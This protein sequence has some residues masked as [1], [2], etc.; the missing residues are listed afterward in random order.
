[1]TTI[2]SLRKHR[3]PTPHDNLRALFSVPDDAPYQQE[4]TAVLTLEGQEE[5]YAGKLYVFAPYLCFLSLDKKSVQFTIPLSTVRRVERLNSRAGVYA[6]SLVTWHNLKIVVQLTSLRPAADAFSGHLRDSLKSQLEL[7]RMKAVK[8]FSRTLYSEAIIPIGGTA[9]TDKEREDGSVIKDPDAPEDGNAIQGEYLGGLGFT[10]KFPGDAKKLR[11]AS[12]IKLWTN[13]MRAHGRHLT[14]LRYPQA[15]RLIQVGLPNRLR[16]ELWETLSGSLYLRF[17]NP[18]LYQK[19]LDDNAGK[20][21]TSTEEIEKDLNRSLPEYAAYQTPQGIGALRRVLTAYSWKN[22]EVGYC[23]A[24]NILVAAIL[25]FMSEEQAFWLLEVLCDRLLPG[26]YVPSMYGTLLDQRVFESLVHKCL[27]IIHDR[28]HEIDVQ[29]S[30]ASLPW[31]LSL[32]IN[33]M[34]L[35]FA[36]RI[37][38]CVLAMGPKVLFQVGTLHNV[39]ILK[40]NGEKLLEISD[41]G[42]FIH[43]MRD[44][45]ASLGDSAHPNSSDPRTRAITNFQELLLVSFREFS[46]ITEE[47][48]AAERK[49]FRT[50]IVTGIESFSKRAA[51][52]NLRTFGTLTKV[53]VGLVYEVLFQSVVDCPPDDVRPHADDARDA[54]GRP[55]TRIGLKTFRVFLSQIATWARDE[56]IVSNGFI[57]RT[58]RDVP[59]HEFINRLFFFWDTNQRG[60]L[61]YQDLVLGLSGVMN[62]DLMSNIEWFFT[63]HDSDRDGYLTKDELLQLSEA[64]LFI[65]R[66]E[67]GDA[68]LGAVSRFMTN[69]FEYGDALLAPE[70]L[71]DGNAEGFSPKKPYLNLATFR[72]VVLADEILESFFDTD[73]SASFQLEPPPVPEELKPQ[74]AGFFG[75]LVSSIMN[76]NDNR[77]IFNNVADSIGRSMGKHQVTTRP[78]IGKFDKGFGLQEPKPRESLLTPTVSGRN[79]SP[80]ASSRLSEKTVDTAATSTGG[81]SQKTTLIDTT[82]IKSDSDSISLS[83]SSTHEPLTPLVQ[84]LSN[85]S[86]MERTHFTIDDAADGDDDDLDDLDAAGGGD[87]D[88]SMMDEV[89]AF[90]EAHDSGLT[91]A[92]NAAAKDLLSAPAI[93]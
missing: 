38:D 9:A 56:K 37:V 41:D 10:F 53:Q 77:R 89:D 86:F 60:A 47:T 70:E 34:P 76:N 27:P 80:S 33:S 1:M 57:E 18:G 24:M 30:V 39:A 32:Y 79:R 43:L 91:G 20:V 62:N 42:Q 55:E 84:Q 16:G 14:L 49:R 4:I 93:K 58:T 7:G 92:E 45:F 72:M 78:S 82:S 90:L 15:T 52:R 69:A 81:G 13:Y 17:E 3:E 73:L 29:L 87:V 48:I 88:Q 50:E 54:A 44:Y 59:E 21:T 12:K 23:Q 22:P 64:M 31:F 61:S 74:K 71:K 19:L 85:T 63:V 66:S 25:I 51:I 8:P 67:A 83:A 5:S 36:F 75:G 2:T 35:I 26:Y 11:E 40:I 65:F 28:F 46:V 6:L 68:Y